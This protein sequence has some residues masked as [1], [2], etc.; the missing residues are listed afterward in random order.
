MMN[1]SKMTRNTQKALS[2]ART[3]AINPGH[4]SVDPVHILSAILEQP[5][6]LGRKLL[7]RTGSDLDAIRH[8]LSIQ[9]KD[10][11]RVSGSGFNPDNICI[12]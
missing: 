9:L 11:P 1:I 10:I 3:I 2:R 12:G 4:P 6:G 5:E 7:A 8:K